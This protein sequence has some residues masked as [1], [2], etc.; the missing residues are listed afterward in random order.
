MAV[1]LET[2]NRIDNCDGFPV[3]KRVP[4]TLRRRRAVSLIPKTRWAAYATAGAASAIAGVNSAEADIHYSGALNIPLD[5]APG[6]SVL[7]TFALDNGAELIF[8][9]SRSANSAGGAFF[10]I[11]GA[12]ISNEFRGKAYGGFRYPSNLGPG[13]IVSAGAFVA[14]SGSKFATLAYHGGYAHSQWLNK[15]TGFIGF[16]FS[17]FAGTE[18]GWAQLTMN[19]GEPGNSFTLKDFAWADSG[20]PIFT[21]ETAVVP[22]PGTLSLLA[23]GAVGLLLWRRQRAN[24]SH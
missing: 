24:A 19:E 15:G 22:E 6:A 4:K 5:A 23:S 13:V 9:H 7:K 11:E 21:G 2:E 10:R 20:T 18:Y 14:H 12:A 17:T 1:S 16:K 8:A 3:K